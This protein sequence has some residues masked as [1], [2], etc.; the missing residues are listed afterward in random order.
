MNTI[1]KQTTPK[2]STREHDAA[3]WETRF[4]QFL[5]HFCINYYTLGQPSHFPCLNN[6]PTHVSF[7]LRD[8]FHGFI[9][10]KWINYL[11]R[12]II[13]VKKYKK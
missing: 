13:L 8:K 12:N 2:T 7:D 6:L 11:I 5:T 9:S 10:C 3:D 4:E 1:F